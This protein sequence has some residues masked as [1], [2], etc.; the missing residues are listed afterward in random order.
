ML[1]NGE[2]GFLWSFVSSL[3]GH[4]NWFS[5]DIINKFKLHQYVC[6]KDSFAG[7]TVFLPVDPD[8]KQERE[9]RFRATWERFMACEPWQGTVTSKATRRPISWFK[10][11]PCLV[12]WY[13]AVPQSFIHALYHMYWRSPWY[14]KNVIILENKR[15]MVSTLNVSLGFQLC[16]ILIR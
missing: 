7:N 9:V 8:K 2:P 15:Q 10:V 3:G 6:S 13:S 4:W 12:C 16:K 5:R 14:S 11:N 1:F